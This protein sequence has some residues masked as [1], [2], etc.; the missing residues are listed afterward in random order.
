MSKIASRA[1]S[2]IDRFGQKHGWWNYR[3][4]DGHV[5]V[6]RNVT[7]YGRNAMHWGVDVYRPKTDDYLCFRLPLPC[8]GRWWRRGC[9]ISPDGTPRKATKW[10]WGRRRRLGE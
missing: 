6:G 4:L 8:F 1:V 7:L 3:F 5:H 2:A 9:Y 10:F